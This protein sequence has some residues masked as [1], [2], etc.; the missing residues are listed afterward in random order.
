[1][2]GRHSARTGKNKNLTAVIVVVVVLNYFYAE[3]IGRTH[4]YDLPQCDVGVCVK[5]ISTCK[6]VKSSD[7]QMEFVV[8]SIGQLRFRFRFALP[9]EGTFPPSLV[10]LGAFVH[11]G[12]C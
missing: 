5:L 1:M 3:N 7:F 6:I 2:T 9:A 10:R 8:R 11:A 4:I 12:R